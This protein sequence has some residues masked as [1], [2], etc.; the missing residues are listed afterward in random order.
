M[1]VTRFLSALTLGA[2][3]V[4]A[5]D[6]N[7]VA[8]G[9]RTFVNGVLVYKDG[10]VNVNRADRGDWTYVCNLNSARDG[11]SV[12]TCA[13]WVSLLQQIKRDGKRAEFWFDYAEGAGGVVGA[14][15]CSNTTYYH[16]APAPVYIGAVEDTP[17]AKSKSMASDVPTMAPPAPRSE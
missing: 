13:M 6:A 14:P 17:P 4:A 10:S 2:L 8:F 11:V 3:C 1:K 12:T 7:A 5:G 16:F 15:A 9:C